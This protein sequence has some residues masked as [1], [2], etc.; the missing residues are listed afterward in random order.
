METYKTLSEKKKIARTKARLEFTCIVIKYCLDNNIEVYNVEVSDIEGVTEFLSLSA[1]DIKPETNE[2]IK[3]AHHMRHMGCTVFEFN[4]KIHLT[5]YGN[6]GSKGLFTL[7]DEYITD[8]LKQYLNE[9]TQAIYDVR[10][11]KQ[12]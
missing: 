4:E 6:S 3:Y 7:P 9:F 8:R 1:Y 5:Y 12:K 2:N 10:K 11:L